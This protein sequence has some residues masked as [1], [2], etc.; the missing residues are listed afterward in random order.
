MDTLSVIWLPVI[1]TAV[2]IF[3]ASSLIHMV[4]KWHNSD[5]KKL[6]NEDDVRAVIRAGSPAPGLYILPH[7]ADMKDMAGEAMQKKYIEGPV[8]MLTVRPSGS[9]G[10]GKPLVLWFVLSLA[11]AAIA[12][13]MAAGAYPGKANAHPAAH[14]AAVITFLAYYIGSVQM[15]IWMGK[16]WS[17]VGKDLLDSIIYAVVTGLVFAWLWG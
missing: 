15:A 14:L 7:C 3:I 11:I 1:V 9:P 4:F 5:Y 8:A 2:A 6:G 17:S 13:C 16:T 10:M 12:A